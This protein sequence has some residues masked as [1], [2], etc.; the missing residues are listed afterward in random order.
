[1]KKIIN[2]LFGVLLML[3]IAVMPLPV[4]GSEQPTAEEMEMINQQLAELSPEQLEQMFNEYL[5]TLS[6]EEQEKLMEEYNNEIAA[7]DESSDEVDKNL[8][9]QEVLTEE[10]A[11]QPNIAVVEAD[12]ADTEADDADETDELP[13]SAE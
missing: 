11:A 9:E 7:L 5:A 10:I 1:M 2:G 3:A 13:E 8:A 6:P 12:D 4:I